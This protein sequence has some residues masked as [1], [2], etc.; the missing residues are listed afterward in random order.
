MWS[1]NIWLGTK[2]DEMYVLEKVVIFSIIHVFSASLSIFC[3]I[4]SY[5]DLENKQFKNIQSDVS[6]TF[7]FNSLSQLYMMLLYIYIY[8]NKNKQESDLVGGNLQKI[9][10]KAY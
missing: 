1:I 7:A 3:T 10:D 5:K 8:M 9:I 6:A 4:S 2:I